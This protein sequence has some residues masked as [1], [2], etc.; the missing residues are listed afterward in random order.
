M[1]K[2]KNYAFPTVP[3]FTVTLGVTEMFLKVILAKYFYAFMLF[4]KYI[5]VYF[6]SSL[7]IPQLPKTMARDVHMRISY[8]NLM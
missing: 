7:P 6:P 8:N 5:S 1:L 2:I 4:F 3:C